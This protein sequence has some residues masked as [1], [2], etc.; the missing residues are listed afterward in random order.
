M[1]TKIACAVAAIALAG[2]A[3]AIKV[4]VIDFKFNP[5]DAAVTGGPDYTG[6]A[7]QFT[8]MLDGTSFAA[9]CIELTQSFNFGADYDYAAVPG[10][11]VF[12]AQKLDD[13]S[14]LLTGTMGF[15][16]D[17][18]TSAALQAAIWE[19]IYQ[20]GD[21]Y[22]LFGGSFQAVPGNSGDA[23]AQAAFNSVNSVLQNLGAYA[24]NYQVNLLVNAEQQDFIIVQEIPE[25]GTW[26]MLF[27]GLGVLGAVARR[28]KVTATA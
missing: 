25:P 5:I 16:T 26:A 9:F 11:S 23:A 14:R 3:A 19:V 6:A 15:V 28:R 20:S 21:A 27:A 18:A 13:L 17:A 4:N 22:D 8:G 10:A 2:P 7:G 24:A 1:Y 12:T